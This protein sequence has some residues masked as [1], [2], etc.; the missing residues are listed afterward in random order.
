MLC[1]HVCARMCMHY[2]SLLLCVCV[3]H[4]RLCVCGGGG[5]VQESVANAVLVF[6]ERERACERG[7]GS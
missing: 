6:M 5:G 1:V 4:A 3:L 2:M 7:G